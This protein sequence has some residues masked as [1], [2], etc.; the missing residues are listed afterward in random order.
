MTN[1]YT[2]FIANWKMYGLNK[3]LNNI[4]KVIKFSNL[5]LFK[6]AKIIYCPPYTIL[7]QFYKKIKNEATVLVTWQNIISIMHYPNREGFDYPSEFDKN[8]GFKFKKNK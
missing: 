2:Y 1:N 5:K 3:S 8:I 4:D 7:S 6:R